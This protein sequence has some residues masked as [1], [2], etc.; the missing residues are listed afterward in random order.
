MIAAFRMRPAFI[1]LLF[2]LPMHGGT[3]QA[4]QASA[5]S[6]YPLG[7]TIL[8]IIEDSRAPVR[9]A[10]FPG[11]ANDPKKLALI[12]GITNPTNAFVVRSGGKPILIDAGWGSDGP[13]KGNTLSTLLELGIAPGDIEQVLVTHMHLDHIS[14]L[15]R[16]GN[17]VFP[18]ASLH[19]SRPEFEY[20]VVKGADATAEYVELARKVAAAY[21]GKVVLFDFGDVVAP[22]ITAES[23]VGHTPGHTA[24][25]IDAGGKRVTIMGDAMHAAE[26]QFTHPEISP[27]FDGDPVQA[28]RTRGALLEKIGAS[29]GFI[30]GGHVAGLHAVRPRPSG[31]FIFVEAR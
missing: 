12:E 18:N 22:G 7:E 11:I 23:A 19:I 5:A 2:I 14:G 15:I 26:L 4:G 9:P 3:L 6:H 30:A 1:F 29:D 10:I 25:N 8:S 21:D 28:A 24:F 13:R 20:W 31:G 17:A 27:I 16:D